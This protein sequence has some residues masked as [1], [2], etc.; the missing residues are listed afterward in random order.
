LASE[1]N[2]QP[3]ADDALE[4]PRGLHGNAAFLFRTQISKIYANASMLAKLGFPDAKKL[5]FGLNHGQNAAE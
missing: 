5:S 3:K 4:C 2:G 1:Q